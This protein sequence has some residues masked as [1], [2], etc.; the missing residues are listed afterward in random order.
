MNIQLILFVWF[1]VVPLVLL[2]IVFSIPKHGPAWAAKWLPVFAVVVSL[3]CWIV[4]PVAYS[5]SNQFEEA[6]A[7]S[8]SEVGMFFWYVI[9]MLFSFS[10]ILG[11]VFAMICGIGSFIYARISKTPLNLV[12]WSSLLLPLCSIVLHVLVDYF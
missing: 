12:I 5:I 1:I 4:C 3:M 8:D 6:H 10:F 9:G 7:A 2:N 11:N